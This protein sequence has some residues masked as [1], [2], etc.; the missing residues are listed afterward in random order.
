M[1]LIYSRAVKMKEY[2]LFFP[3]EAMTEKL[4]LTAVGNNRYRLEESSFSEAG[5]FYHDMIEA[6]HRLGKGLCFLR[7]LE[8]A[9]LSGL[10]GHCRG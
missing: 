10:V 7:V 1:A 5:V 9:G 8:R 2:T 3:D 4:L 6:K